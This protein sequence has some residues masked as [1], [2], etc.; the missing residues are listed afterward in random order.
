MT[1][2]AI[3]I[4]TGTETALYPTFQPEVLSAVDPSTPASVHQPMRDSLDVF[5][6]FGPL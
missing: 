2:Y 3:S 4:Q 6:I 1:S 5:D